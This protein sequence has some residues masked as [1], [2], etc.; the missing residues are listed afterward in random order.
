MATVCW[1]YFD[2]EYENFSNRINP[3]RVS[4]DNAS[5]HDCTL[6][7]VDSVNKPGILLELVQILT[8]LDFI[9][10]KA[11]I[12]SDGGWFMDV[13]HVTDQQGKKITDIKT[14]DFIEKALGPKGQSTDGAKSWPA[15]RIGVHSI[16]DHT[17]I[18]LIGRDRPGL[19][20]EISA[21]LANLQFN[22]IAAEV[23]THN[24]RIACV[25]YVNDAATGAVDNPNKL[26]L[27]EEQL[28]N[29]LRGCENDEKVARTSFSMGF[30]HMDRRLHQ[31]LF[32][33]RDYECTGVMADVDYP[34]CF[35]PKISIERCEEKGYSVVSVSCK[36]RAKLM[37]D[38]VCTLTDMQYV[39]F[40]ATISSDGPHASQEYFIRHMDGCTL[41]TEAEKERVIKCIEAAIQR[42]VSEGVSLELCAKDRVGLLS[43]VTRILRE[44]GLTVCRAA[45]ST[46]GEQA[47]NV[48]YVRDASGNPVDMK[49]VEALRK[50]IGQTMMVKVKR[51]AT[52]AETPETRGWAKTGFF[53]G[54]L[55]ERFLS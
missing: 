41:D 32:A 37:F 34:P 21:V 31:M 49:I 44:N 9:I 51:V 30:T 14:I 45:V 36:D 29:I 18:E 24:R 22:V 27:M 39:V 42:R 11:Y 46:I 12:S 55:L 52:D 4:V 53:F 15:K 26:S 35:R 40:H 43:E 20:S 38:I 13:F 8:D 7:K 33:D 2:P 17:A 3:P 10:T 6:I 25:L 1:P 5:C 23:W 28:K 19:L 16:G 47:L 54:N 50:E 48:F